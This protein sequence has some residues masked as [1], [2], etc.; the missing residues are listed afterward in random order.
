MPIIALIKFVLHPGL[1]NLL[2]Q[3]IVN[4]NDKKIHKN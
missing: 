4:E 3:A 1:E 2:E